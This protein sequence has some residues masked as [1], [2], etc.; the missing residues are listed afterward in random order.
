MLTV[1]CS[2]CQILCFNFIVILTLITFGAHPSNV[3]RW[4]WPVARVFAL[5]RKGKD[6]VEQWMSEHCCLVDCSEGM[7]AAIQSFLQFKEQF[8]SGNEQ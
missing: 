4:F 2:S 7:T 8:R 6:F 3:S 1:H 5:V